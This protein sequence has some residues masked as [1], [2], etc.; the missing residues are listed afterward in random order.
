MMQLHRQ[1]D[2]RGAAYQNELRERIRKLVNRNMDKTNALVLLMACFNQ[3]GELEEICPD[4]LSVAFE[5]ASK[6]LQFEQKINPHFN[7]GKSLETA[8]FAK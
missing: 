7:I 4:Q 3:Q 6:A 2:G 8:R 5:A 1:R